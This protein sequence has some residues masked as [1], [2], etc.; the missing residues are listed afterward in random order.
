[1]AMEAPLGRGEM[2]ALWVVLDGV[3]QVGSAPGAMKQGSLGT[4]AKE[5]QQKGCDPF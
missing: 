3:L 2:L 1:M 4:E 5:L